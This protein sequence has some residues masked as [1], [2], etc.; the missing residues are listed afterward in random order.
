VGAIAVLNGLKGAVMA[1]RAFVPY[2]KAILSTEMV[3]VMKIQFDVALLDE[4]FT[5]P[6]VATLEIETN[7]SDNMQ[8][9]KTKIVDAILVH[10]AA[11]NY[12]QMQAAN[13]LLPQYAKG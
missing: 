1:Q 9:I 10:A 11:N 6:L 12:S 5:E 8:T 7:W 2:Y 13:V 4:I 3:G